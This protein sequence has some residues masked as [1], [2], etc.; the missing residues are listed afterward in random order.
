VR[1]V[2]LHS[3]TV[4]FVQ[5]PSTD[6]RGIHFED[7]PSAGR[8]RVARLADVV[9]LLTTIASSSTALIAF[10]SGPEPRREVLVP[11]FGLPW[12]VE[13]LLSDRVA[14]GVDTQAPLHGSCGGVE[15]GHV[16]SSGGGYVMVPTRNVLDFLS[17]QLRT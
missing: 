2:F 10:R 15:V 14:I 1:R 16:V 6:E 4:S 7:R 11:T 12:S 13:P 3:R 17:L 5:P 9:F 8:L